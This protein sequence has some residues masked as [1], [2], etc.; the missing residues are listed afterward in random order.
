MLDTL[1][2]TYQGL[3]LY[4]RAASLHTKARPSARA[5]LGPDHPDTLTSRNGLAGAYCRRPDGP[6]PSRC[7]RR[8]SRQQEARLGPDH[9]DTLASRSN[10]ALAYA[11]RGPIDRGHRAARGDAQLWKRSWART[12]PT[13]SWPQQPGHRLLGRRPES[14]AIALYEATLEA[15]E[16]R[17][18]PDHPDT[19]VSRNNLAVAWRIRADARG[20]D[21]VRGDARGCRRPSSAPTIPTRT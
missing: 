2:T 16:A 9:P 7:T 5:A 21:V 12:T 18:G 4:D 3:G 19:L 14:E 1:G 15:A 13:L 8:R 17:L 20:D 10:L 6:R 11:A